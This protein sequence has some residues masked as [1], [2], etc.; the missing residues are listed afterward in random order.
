MSSFSH[1]TREN[2][3]TVKGNKVV[4]KKKKKVVGERDR[5]DEE[6]REKIEDT[7]TVYIKGES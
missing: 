6:R 1:F 3:Q 5:K 2:K 7:G 4:R